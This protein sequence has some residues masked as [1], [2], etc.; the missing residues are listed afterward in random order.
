MGDHA[1]R[2]KGQGADSIELFNTGQNGRRVTGFRVPR[3]ELS[4]HIQRQSRHLPVQ[5]RN[6][7]RNRNRN[8][9]SSALLP[10]MGITALSGN[11]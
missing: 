9:P 7:N 5:Y 10:R 2:A 4:L 6:R 11:S 8:L 1:L 3:M